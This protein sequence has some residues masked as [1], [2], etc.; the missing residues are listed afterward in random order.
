MKHHLMIG[1]WTPPG[2]IFTVEFDDSKLTLEL[3]K[4]TE[5]PQDQ[6]ISWMTFD[7]ARKNIYGAGMKKWGSYTVSSPTDIIH[8]AS[9]PMG[10]HPRANDL[11]TKTRAI[12]VLA[13][14]KAPYCVY[15]NPFYDHA[16]FLNV[17]SVNSEGGLDKNIQ[18]APLDENSAIHG[19]VFDSEEEYLYSADMWA[20]KI[21]CHK[22]NPQTGTL[23]LIGSTPAP[24]PNDHPRWVEISPSNAYLYVLMESGNRLCIY[25]IDEKT[26]LPVYTRT[27]YPLIPPEMSN[28]F[29]KMFRSD[30]VFKSQSGQYLFA[31]SRSNSPKLTGYISAFQLG[32]E[33]QVLRQICL[34]PTP[35]S[36]GH[37]NAVSPCPWT[38]EWVALCDDEQGWVEIYRWH[39]E[40]LGRVAHMD[41]K[42][43]GFGM[44]AIWYD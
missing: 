21:W 30:V 19:M 36:G 26:H 4:R 12:F 11:D 32:K 16:G 8:H 2:A 7:H 24:S 33:G 37:S 15:G 9:I 44:N 39:E 23:S 42:E 28:L 17:H 29:P 5:I 31:T 43:P 40:F 14:K 34:N 41:V 22:K 20:N 25:I 38:D 1:T 18:N 27:S 6:P 3:V 35:T 10:G 13:A